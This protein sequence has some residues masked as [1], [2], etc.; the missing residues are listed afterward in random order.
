MLQI[1]EGGD[2]HVPIDME[3]SKPSQWVLLN[4]TS[5]FI[6][7]LIGKGSPMLYKRNKTACIILLLGVAL[8]IGALT[9]ASTPVGIGGEMI[10]GGWYLWY[11]G[12]AWDP[13][14]RLFYRNDTTYYYKIG[15]DSSQGCDPCSGTTTMTCEGCA[16]SGITCKGGYFTGAERGT[17]STAVWTG[18][19]GIGGICDGETGDLD[20]FEA[21]EVE[22]HEADC[23]I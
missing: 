16:T 15:C 2:T 23:P 11:G 20:S 12:T 14:D 17:G 18:S 1:A 9:Y 21:C 8:G 4:R 3:N 5:E 10:T 6:N 22:L 13:D 7:T 19:S